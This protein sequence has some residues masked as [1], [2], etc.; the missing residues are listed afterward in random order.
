[1]RSNGGL[2]LLINYP[3]PLFSLVAGRQE[4]KGKKIC[5]CFML[6]Q[7]QSN[8]TK[9]TRERVLCNFL[10]FFS[11]TETNDLA[12]Q[13]A[14]KLSIREKYQNIYQ[15]YADEGDTI[16]LN[17]VY[18]NLHVIEGAWE[19][20]NVEHDDR[21]QMSGT[22]QSEETSIQ[23]CDIFKPHP[24]KRIRTVLTQ[25]MPGMGKTVC[26]QKFALSW[27][28][29]KENEDIYFLFMLPFR[30]LN[31]NIGEKDCSLMQLLYQFFP[32]LKPLERLETRH[33]VLFIFDGLDET[34]LP[35]KFTENKVIR[36]ET[37]AASLDA[38]V[39]NLIAGNL[40]G[41]SLIWITSRPAAVG[42]VDRKYIHQWTEVKGFTNEA[43]EEY[44]RRNVSDENLARRIISHVK[45]SRNFYI[46]CQIPL[47]CWITAT[48]LTKI[49]LASGEG[50]M[51]NTL[52]EMYIYLLLRQTDQMMEGH[53]PVDSNRVVLKLAQ[54]AF[55]QL[56]KGQVNFYEADLRECGMDVKEATIYSGMCTKVFRKGGG[57]SGDIFQFVHLTVQEFLAAVHV[58]HAYLQQK[59]N[60]FD[61]GYLQKMTTKVL[62][63]SLFSLHKPAIEKALKSTSGHW[64]I[65][66]RFLLGLSLKSNQELL[67]RALRLEAEAVEDVAKTIQFIKEKIK[68]EPEVKTNLF[69]CLSELK[70]ESLVQEVQNLVSSGKS[71]ANKLSPVQWSALTF[72][73]MTSEAAVQEFN[74]K[75]YA[76]SDEALV[77]LQSVII[78]SSRAL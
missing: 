71:A 16:Y 37:E 56:D 77:R 22:L 10:L 27:A 24:E 49:L 42:Q 36:D 23:V 31:P 25:G 50:G 18:T 21:G 47:F 60:V 57:R 34:R 6:A 28:E 73:L 68:E 14:L 9:T 15:G 35:L 20:F 8:S 32:E 41:K 4:G 39:T 67:A 43:K 17:K 38:I 44:F 61:N 63:K 53:Y 29:G 46:M 3:L 76:R 69:Q 12:I 65:F 13:E 54:L 75:N 52:T 58:H 26:T 72:D 30:E 7:A 74:L 2:A 78:S 5:C 11:P 1:M 62:P 66:L 70:D 59:E 48:V 33:K 55:H 51:P 64:D 45:S 19:G 40:L